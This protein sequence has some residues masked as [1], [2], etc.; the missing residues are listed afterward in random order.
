MCPQ[1]YSVKIEVMIQT[2]SCMLKQSESLANSCSSFFSSHEQLPLGLF[3]WLHGPS[4]TGS[5][6]KVRRA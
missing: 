1:Q 6:S 5:P 4:L 2:L 3:Y